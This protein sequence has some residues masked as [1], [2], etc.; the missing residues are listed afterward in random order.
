MQMSVAGL[1]LLKRSEGFRA[2]VYR[3]AN[4]Y[5][6]GYGHRL[7]GGE[8]FP[9]GV[10]EAEA[11]QILRADVASAEAA[12]ARLVRVPVTQGQFDALVD[13]CYNLGSTRLGSSTLLTLLN[14]GHS[15]TAALQLLRWDHVGGAADAG[16][17]AR[18]R[19]EYELWTGSAQS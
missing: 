17:L 12:V 5:S 19:Q 14:G 13:F 4:G 18:R 6:V 1:E 2:A 16:L 7:R 15:A 3:D 9:E 8:T 11:E 10:T